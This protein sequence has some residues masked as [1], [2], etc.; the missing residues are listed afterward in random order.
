MRSEMET[1]VANQNSA[2]MKEE[3][4]RLRLNFWLIALLIIS[5]E[6]LG[7]S[8]FLPLLGWYEPFVY[9][10]LL[11]FF[12]F[13]FLNKLVKRQNFNSLEIYS[14]L[15]MVL[16]PLQ[17]GISSYYYWGQ[18]LIFGIGSQRTW[19]FS[20]VAILLFYQLQT[21]KITVYEIRDSLLASAW[22]LL[23]IFSLIYVFFIVSCVNKLIPRRIYLNKVHICFLQ[24]FL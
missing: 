6:T 4:T 11:I 20:L 8:I 22:G 3:S 14:I 13:F 12:T 9:F 16:L 21:R 10:G 19:I 1:A 24:S 15:L 23:I 17:S 18:P 5:F 7:R 2:S